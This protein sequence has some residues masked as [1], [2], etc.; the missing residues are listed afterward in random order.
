MSG[1]AR[2]VVITG[3]GAVTAAGV[4]CERLWSALKRNEPLF[5]PIKRFEP[6]YP[7]PKLAAQVDGFHADRW[8]A[9]A[10]IRQTDIGTHFA[11]ASVRMALQD[12]QLDLESLDRLRAGVTVGHALGGMDYAEPQLYNQYVFGPEEV[13]PYQSIAWFYAATMGQLSIQLGLK[14]Y[15]KALV[16]DRCSGMHAIGHGFRVVQSGRADVIV[17]GGLEAPL[18]PFMYRTLASAGQLSCGDYL[19]FSRESEGF[20]IGEGACFLILEALDHARERGAKVYAEIAGYGMTTDPFAGR[21]LSDARELFRAQRLALEE[22]GQPAV[23]DHV[24]ADGVAI[25]EEDRVEME[26]LTRL[27]EGSWR[28][29][30]VSVPKTIAGEMYGGGAPLQVL[31]GALSLDLGTCLPLIA[32]DRALIPH[33]ATAREQDLRQ[34]LVNSRGIGGVNASLVL[35]RFGSRDYH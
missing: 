10:L 27:F 24:L 21:G 30:K 9:P 1:R 35:R 29:C 16:A 17:A 5:T 32:D 19:P 33:A 3:L 15:S 12:S 26:A 11:F 4:G 34:V 28:D 18:S 31:A 2:R 25:R 6:R 8:M 22:S 14:G 13:G 7:E 23:V 20:I